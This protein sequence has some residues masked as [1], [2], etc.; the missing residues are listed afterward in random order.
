MSAYKYYENARESKE[1]EI[2]Q[3]FNMLWYVDPVQWY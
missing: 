1:K 3:L 2:L